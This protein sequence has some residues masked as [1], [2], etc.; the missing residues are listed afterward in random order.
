[1][2]FYEDSEV[3]RLLK[4]SPL[5]QEHREGLLMLLEQKRSQLRQERFQE[6]AV[7]TSIAASP[8]RQSLD[9]PLLYRY[10]HAPH[11]ALSVSHSR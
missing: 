9:R 7:S 5:K 10:P 3:L 11:H 8:V 2:D 4:A 6:L 1:M